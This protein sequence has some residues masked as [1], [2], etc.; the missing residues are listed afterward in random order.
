MG[1][2]QLRVTGLTHVWH[3]E[4]SAGL[5]Q[6]ITRLET[7]LDALNAQNL[8]LLTDMQSLRTD[9]LELRTEVADLKRRPARCIHCRVRVNM[10]YMFMYRPVS[11]LSGRKEGFV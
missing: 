11:L 5:L 6:S 8:Q 10:E 7:K 1:N 2:E 9:N 4:H 3:L